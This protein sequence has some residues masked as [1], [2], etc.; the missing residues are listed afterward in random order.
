MNER[1]RHAGGQFGLPHGAGNLQGNGSGQVSL[2]A[3]HAP[4][5]HAKTIQSSAQRNL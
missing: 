4:L 3:L 1:E 5:H 2:L